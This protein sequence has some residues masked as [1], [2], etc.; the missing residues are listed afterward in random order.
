MNSNVIR[1]AMA[2]RGIP[3][4]QIAEKAGVSTSAVYK[5]IQGNRQTNKVLEVVRELLGEDIDA[6]QGGLD[7]L[8]EH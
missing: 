6:L 3:A 7:E 5:T 1:A 2:L 8:E 4:S